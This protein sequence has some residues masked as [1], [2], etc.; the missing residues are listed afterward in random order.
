MRFR[1]PLG[2]NG[3]IINIL[4]GKTGREQNP[5][6]PQKIMDF[7]DNLVPLGRI[8]PPFWRPQDI[9]GGPQIDRLKSK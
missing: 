8:G 1:R 2:P 7:F 5:P 3:T 9:E 4:S 6:T